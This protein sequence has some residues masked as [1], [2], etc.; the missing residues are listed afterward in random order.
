MTAPTLNDPLAVTPPE[1]REL[2][3]RLELDVTRRLDGLLHGDHRGLVPGHGSELGETRRYAP[4]DDVRRIDWNVSARLQEPH[5][6][7]T[8]AERELQTWLVVDRSPR[9]DFGTT[10]AEKR[11]LALAA[12]AA[13]GFLTNRDGNQIGALFAG[14][15]A[16]G[17]RVLVPP[18]GSRRHFLSILSDIAA[19]PRADGVGVTDLGS[20]L[21]RLASVSRRRGLVVVISDFLVA[22]GWE[23]PMR[24]LGQRHDVLAIQVTDPREREL[25]DVGVVVLRDPATGREHEVA[26]HK[27]S[28]RERFA[29]A[30]AERQERLEAQLRVAR[31][32]HLVLSTDRFWLDDLVRFVALRNA[33]LASVGRR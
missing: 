32:D 10:G 3:R 7:Q 29:A 4:G 26:T 5:I 12:A 8:I 18:K 9:I 14:P 11:Q 2:L 31:I 20:A 33:R 19:S 28:V 30:A 15:P 16:M 21:A 6:R 23:D 27:R 17:G 22:P 24:I 1:T 13:V 25:P